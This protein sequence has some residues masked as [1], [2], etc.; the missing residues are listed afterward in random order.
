MKKKILGVIAAFAVI[1]TS[2]V[3]FAEEKTDEAELK[4]V[5]SCETEEKMV[6]SYLTGLDVPESIGRRRP[7]AIMMSNIINAVP[8]S[9]ISSA[10][11]V[12]EAP[13]EGEITRLMAL[14]EEYED[15]ER[16]GS[17]RSCRDYYI[18]YAHE[19]DA[20]YCHFGQ[21]AYAVPYFEQKL[22]DNINGLYFDGTAYFRTSDRQAPHNAYT[23]AEYIQRGIDQLGYRQTF[24][25]D[26]DGHF[27]FAEEGTET[28]LDDGMTANVV[29]LDN[30]KHNN[31]WFEYDPE[32]KKYKRFQFGE[33]QIDELTGEQL[34]CDN[35]ILLY[36]SCPPYDGN[37]YLNIDVM[38]PGKGKFITR[39][40][41][42]D[43]RWE[44]DAPWGVTH[45]IDTNEQEIRVNTGTTWIL[46]VQDD[47]VDMV[48]YE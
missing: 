1:C 26:Y 38:T 24:K 48:T 23:N 4:T 15:L 30:F 7:L 8:Q 29:R 11:V 44:K 13:V 17:V 41:A 5:E 2:S 40:K 25:E 22:I 39:G 12:Y 3:V 33:A 46:I 6:K 14:F 21:S 47:R 9:G 18:F 28:T 20:I 31:P 43:I 10:G 36:A 42:V 16:I 32:T 37:G 19:F 45:Y 35:I 34:T 27:I